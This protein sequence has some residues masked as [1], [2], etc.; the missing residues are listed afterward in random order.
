MCPRRSPTLAAAAGEAS[1][2]PRP[3]GRPLCSSQTAAVSCKAN[4]P[5]PRRVVG[6]SDDV[7]LVLW[8]PRRPDVPMCNRCCCPSKRAER[9]LPVAG[10][11]LAVS[12]MSEV[13]SPRRMHGAVSE[14]RSRRP[15][16][17]PQAG[18]ATL[19]LRDDGT[20]TKTLPGPQGAV[21]SPLALALVQV[22]ATRSTA[23]HL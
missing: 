9:A 17:A 3:S 5:V 13:G 12:G 7:A 20:V 2:R 11:R 23:Q 15:S 22:L 18:T 21:G 6:S 14:S 4:S 16:P 8:L 10:R 1:A 19:R